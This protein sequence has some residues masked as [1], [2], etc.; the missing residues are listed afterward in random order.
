MAFTSDGVISGGTFIGLANG[1]MPPT[2]TWQGFLDSFRVTNKE[3]ILFEF[4]NYTNT[5]NTG[6]LVFGSVWE[7]EAIDDIT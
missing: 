3:P 5:A 6:D 1:Q 4:E 7:V 2:N